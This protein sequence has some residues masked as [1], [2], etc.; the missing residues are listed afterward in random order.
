M[1]WYLASFYREETDSYKSPQSLPLQIRTLLLTIIAY[2][3][4]QPTRANKNQQ[5]P[6]RTNKTGKSASLQHSQPNSIHPTAT[7]PG[8]VAQYIMA[9]T[10]YW[11]CS[12]H[13]DGHT[14]S[15]IN[16]IMEQECDEC[17]E[18][19]SSGDLAM[20]DNRRVQGVFVDFNY[21][22]YDG[23]GSSKSRRSGGGGGSSRRS[24]GSGT[25]ASG[26]GR[27]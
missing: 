17:G 4:T 12:K 24:G 15:R 11:R 19:R 26:A 25:V 3:L 9:S 27:R 8:R 21:V 2:S 10:T 20:G 6:T 13:I 14:C 18:T 16:P 5:E 7:M 1:F 23:P 22:L